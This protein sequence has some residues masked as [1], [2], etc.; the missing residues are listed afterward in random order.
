MRRLLALLFPLMTLTSP[1]SAQIIEPGGRPEDIA[2]AASNPDE[3]AWRLFL[4]M[5]RQAAPKTAGVAD[6][7]KSDIKQ[8]DPDRPVVWETWA[9]ASGGSA[10]NNRSEVFK[11]PA[12]APVAWKDLDRSEPKEPVLSPS[13]KSNIAVLQATTRLRSAL[14]ANPASPPAVRSGDVSVFAAPVGVRPSDQEVRMNESTYNTVRSKVL[15]SVEGLEAAAQKA[16]ASGATSLVTFEPASK[17][18]KAVWR[19]LPD[20]QA[21]QPCM[22]KDRY[23]WRVVTNPGNNKKEVWGLVALHIITKDLPNWFWSDFGH[24]DCETA[25]SACDSHTSTGESPLRDATTGTSVPGGIGPSGKNGKRNE[26]LGS[27]WENYRLR[28]TQ[29]AFISAEGRP[30]ILS[31]P[32]IEDGFQ[33]SSCIACHARATVALRAD[34]PF[35]GKFDSSGIAVFSSLNNYA[36][37]LGSAPVPEEAIGMSNEDCLQFLPKTVSACPTDREPKVPV[38]FQ[39]DFLWSLPFRAFSKDKETK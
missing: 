25:Q 11:Y 15:Y 33:K 14:R 24:I 16:K 13:F 36:R 7:S 26:T 6:A 30:T 27:K 12:T 38:Y 23:H 20:C 18:V 29:I 3:Y 8:Y 17:E 21:E 32:V 37:N 10:T 35:G 1:L 31:N 34:V 19:P 9:F 22:Q 4:F 28:G 5:N 2:L 39:S